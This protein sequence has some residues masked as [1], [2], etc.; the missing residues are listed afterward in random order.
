[1]KPCTTYT[2]DLIIA[3]HEKLEAKK[4]RIEELEEENAR[5]K[6]TINGIREL[7]AEWGEEEC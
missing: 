5:L 6:D 3:L 7:I 1:M 4:E 2:E